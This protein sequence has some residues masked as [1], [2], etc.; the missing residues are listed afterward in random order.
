[1]NRNAADMNA[2]NSSKNISMGR[3][4]K[5]TRFIAMYY[6]DFNCMIFTVLV[7]INKPAFVLSSLRPLRLLIYLLF[8]LCQ[9]LDDLDWCQTDVKGELFLAKDVSSSLKF[10]T[11][12]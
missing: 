10:I 1:M 4:L 11:R 2:F 9:F 3:G 8:F 6:V 7:V 12:N 5:T